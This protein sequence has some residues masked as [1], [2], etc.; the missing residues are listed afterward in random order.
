MKLMIAAMAVAASTAACV[1]TSGVVQDGSDGYRIMT[2]GK[3]GAQTSGKLQS[4]NY[5][6]ASKYCAK[7]GKVVETLS[8]DSKQSRPLGGFPEANLHFRCVDRAQ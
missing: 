6:T 2:E 4:Q 8:T 5:A 7:Q 1:S 3:T